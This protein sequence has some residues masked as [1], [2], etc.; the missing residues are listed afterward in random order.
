[1]LSPRTGEYD[2]VTKRRIY[3][4][5]GVPHY[6]IVDARHH[7]HRECVLGS[8][9]TYTD[10]VLGTGQPFEPACFPGLSIDLRLICA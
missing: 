2:V 3:E 4:Q 1:M 7:T 10:R 5:H 8:D 6:W 9:G